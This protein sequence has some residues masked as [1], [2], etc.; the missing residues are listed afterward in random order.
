MT[1][2]IIKS[3]EIE[4]GLV[5][6]GRVYLCG[7]LKGPNGVRHIKTEGYE[8]GISDYPAYKFEKAHIHK[9]NI[10]YN[11]IIEGEMKILL[12][13]ERREYHFKKGDFFAIHTDEPYVG[14]AKAGTR[15]IF[16]KVP[17]GN[18]KVLVPVDEAV[19]K[20]GSTWDAVYEG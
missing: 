8:I 18:D 2:E 11:Y 20:W 3:G 4:N 9:F 12:L 14:K 13:N 1:V 16:S 19:L 5:E 10:E 6:T 7:D 15:T 17:G